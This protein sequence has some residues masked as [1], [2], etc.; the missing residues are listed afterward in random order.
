MKRL[1][2]GDATAK[3]NCPQTVSQELNSSN[4]W[5][6][7]L[8]AFSEERRKSETEPLKQRKKRKLNVPAGRGI[9]GIEGT[10]LIN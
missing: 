4:N 10:I 8:K 2:D 5:T 6:D 3:T 7:S 9:E 1:P